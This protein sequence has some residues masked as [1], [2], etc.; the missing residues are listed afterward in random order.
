M[1]VLLIMSVSCHIL[2]FPSLSPQLKLI[3]ASPMN[4]LNRLL[5][6][7]KREGQHEPSAVSTTGL[8]GK[9]H[10]SWTLS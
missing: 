4:F 6:G 10:T 3:K 7:A 1:K 5:E 8:P 9:H 2:F